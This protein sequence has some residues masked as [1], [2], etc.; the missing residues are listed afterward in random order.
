M[1]A[2]FDAYGGEYEALVQKSIAF[3]GVAHD[4]FVRAKIAL[5]SDV[6]ERHFDSAPPSLLDVGCGVGAM[7][8]GLASITRT[9]SG[10]DLSA[11]SLARARDEHPEVEYREGHDD[12]LPWQDAN[13]DVALAVCVLHHVPPGERAGLL[14]EMRRV[15]RPGGL[16]VVIEHNP[17]NPLTRLAVARC[18]FD[19]DAVLLGA[20]EARRGLGKVGLTGVASRHFLVFPS[21]HRLVASVERR[22]GGV[23]LGAQYMAFGEVPGAPAC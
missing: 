10:T 14:A 11:V 12:A 15:T 21:V 13:F 20:G 23:P 6:F 19:H 9:L 2:G 3:S 7:H 5:L 1:T 22:L 17:W 18:P 16:V 4:V 8:T